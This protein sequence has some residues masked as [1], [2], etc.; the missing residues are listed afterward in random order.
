[1]KTE[2]RVFEGYVVYNG[3]VV[4][5]VSHIENGKYTAR[6][7]EGLVVWAAY[8]DDMEITASFYE[9]VSK[10]EAIERFINKNTDDLVSSYALHMRGPNLEVEKGFKMDIYKGNKK[11][12]SFFVSE[13]FKKTYKAFI[14]E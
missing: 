1:M 12:H 13:R 8:P 14:E 2:I 6:I 11:I 5:T 4:D 7:E 3:N 9:A 10:E